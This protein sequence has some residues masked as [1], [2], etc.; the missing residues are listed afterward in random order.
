[1]EEVVAINV[2]DS[3]PGGELHSAVGGWATERDPVLALIEVATSA[4]ILG[5]TLSANTLVLVGLARQRRQKPYSR[6]YRL[7]AHL[8]IADILVGLLCTLPQLAWDI[9]FR[10][11]GNALLCKLVKWSQVFSLYLSTYM[12]VAMSI[13]RFLAVHVPL[14]SGL[15]PNRLVSGLVRAS[16]VIAITAALPQLVVFTQVD[17]G[18]GVEECWAIASPFVLNVYVI[19]FMVVAFVLPMIIMTICYG[20]ICRC[21]YIYSRERTRALTGGTT[22]VGSP[23]GSCISDISAA[24]AQ[25]LKMT[26]TVVIC[27]FLC[28][29]PFC[30]ATLYRQFTPS[31]EVPPWVLPWITILLLLPS[32]NSCT[33]PW[34]YLAFSSGLLREIK[35]IFGIKSKESRDISATVHRVRG[36]YIE[37]K[38]MKRQALEM[39]RKISRDDPKNKRGPPQRFLLARRETPQTTGTQSGQCYGQRFDAGSAT[40]ATIPL[41]VISHSKGNSALTPLIQIVHCYDGP[42]L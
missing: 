25:T 6:M 35:N 36:H 9:S 3:P 33:N 31:N 38:P 30:A 4:V 20:Y 37:G 8:S 22:R 7:M 10:F 28:W 32:L 14:S 27:F 41:N 15:S 19:Y 39:R 12:L 5:L 40:E 42:L 11:Q 17:I 1:M 13:D 26:L 24:K 21:L 34:I 23:R 2:S 18:N 16:Y 29:V